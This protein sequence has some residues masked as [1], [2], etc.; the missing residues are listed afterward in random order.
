MSAVLD[1]YQNQSFPISNS[2]FLKRSIRIQSSRLPPDF[3]GPSNSFRYDTPLSS[4][5]VRKQ[6]LGRIVKTPSFSYRNLVDKNRESDEETGRKVQTA[7]ASMSKNEGQS[8]FLDEKRVQSRNKNRVMRKLSLSYNSIESDG[9]GVKH[10]RLPRFV[11]K[12]GRAQ[13]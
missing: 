8:I 3:F 13:N 10:L 12:A 11:N 2:Y 9:R 5:Q 6:Q 1:S 7:R 4:I